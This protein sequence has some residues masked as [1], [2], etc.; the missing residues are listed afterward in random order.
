[1]NTAASLLLGLLAWILPL[2]SLARLKRTTRIHALHRTCFASFLCC[3]LALAFQ[4]H[5]QLHLVEMGYW[6]ALEDTTGAIC[7]AAGVL[8]A[9]T[10]LV[11]LP[12]LLFSAGEGREPEG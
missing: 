3:A 2:M 11:N 7:F 5:Y 1:M 6:G 4:L 12:L 10:V 9:G 8:L